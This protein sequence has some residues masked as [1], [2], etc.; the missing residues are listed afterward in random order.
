MKTVF[1]IGEVAQICKVKPETVIRWC[2]S[3]QLRGYR[4]P[5]TKAWRVHR[6]RLRHFMKLH[7]FPMDDLERFEQEQPVSGAHR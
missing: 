1:S 3:G 6:D 4:I 7:D 5:Q 2:H